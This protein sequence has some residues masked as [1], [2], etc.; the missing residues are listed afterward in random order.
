MERKI[1]T[2]LNEF[3]KVYGIMIV[4]LFLPFAGLPFFNP[5]GMKFSPLLLGIILLNMI[6]VFDLWRMKEIELT[7]AGLIVTD[8]FF[9][10]Q[11]T[12]FVPFEQI[13]AVESKFRW[14]SSRNRIS[15]KFTEA[16]ALGMD[17]TFI[18]KGFTR[19]AHNEV[20][21]ELT[22]AVSRHKNDKRLDAAARQLKN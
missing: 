20:Y 13:D 8:R 14:L 11:K 22:R 18:S 15:V 4:L 2:A 6:F 17:I 9:F 1:S 3:Y 16:T 21:E 5:F 10:N 19:T 12:V 7:D